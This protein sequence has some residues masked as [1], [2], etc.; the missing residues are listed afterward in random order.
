M[1]NLTTQIRFLAAIAH[2]AAV[3]DFERGAL[4]LPETHMKGETL[5]IGHWLK[6]LVTKLS[7]LHRDLARLA[8]EYGTEGVFGGQLIV[9]QPEESWEVCL[10]SISWVSLVANHPR[11][12]RIYCEN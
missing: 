6:E 4:S 9:A 2:A 5:C 11:L 1:S 10:V 3:G 12:T 7:A 8:R